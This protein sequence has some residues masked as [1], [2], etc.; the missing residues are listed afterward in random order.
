MAR[1]E[2]R[3]CAYYLLGCHR[4]NKVTMVDSL[5]ITFPQ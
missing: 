3:L 1:V 4:K 5:K 2:M